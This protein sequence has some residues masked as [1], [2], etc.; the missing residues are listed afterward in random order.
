MLKFVQTNSLT[1]AR[2]GDDLGYIRIWATPPRRLVFWDGAPSPHKWYQSHTP[3]LVICGRSPKTGR[4]SLGCR[5]RHRHRCSERHS[6]AQR[7]GTDTGAE[8][9]TVQCSA[10]KKGAGACADTGTRASG[11]AQCSA[12]QRSTTIKTQVWTLC[13]RGEY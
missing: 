6:V 11:K 7:K 1:L 8:K 5:H 12:A 9:Y 13:L 10:A 3:N 2:Q 4:R